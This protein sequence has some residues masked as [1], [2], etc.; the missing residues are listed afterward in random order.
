M[1]II[2][3]FCICLFPDPLIPLELHNDWVQLES[4]PPD[5]DN[6][7]AG[8]AGVR[9]TCKTMLDDVWNGEGTY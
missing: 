7:A 2:F 6:L 8:L 9:Q 4:H 1:L 3:E 5:P